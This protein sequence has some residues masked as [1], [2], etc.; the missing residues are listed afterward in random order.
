MRK[1]PI[2]LELTEEMTLHSTITELCEQAAEDSATDLIERYQLEMDLVIKNDTFPGTSNAFHWGVGLTEKDRYLF[3]TSVKYNFYR[4]VARYLQTFLFDYHDGHYAVHFKPIKGQKKSTQCYYVKNV[5][6]NIALMLRMIIQKGHL[7]EGEFEDMLL[8]LRR[9]WAYGDWLEAYLPEPNS[10]NP[11]EYLSDPNLTKRDMLEMM[12][13]Y[14]H[15]YPP[16]DLL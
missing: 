6:K 1:E 5:Q 14:H 15:K 9:Y 7:S 4:V 3:N 10:K 13:P 12:K 11:F 2:K 16:E 8:V